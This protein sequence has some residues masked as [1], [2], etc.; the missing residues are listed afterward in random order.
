MAERNSVSKATLITIVSKTKTKRIGD[1]PLKNVQ[2]EV[3]TDNEYEET[4]STEGDEVDDEQE[5]STDG[6]EM[7]DEDSTEGDEVDDEQEDS[8][9]GEGESDDDTSV[10]DQEVDGV[11]WEEWVEESSDDEESDDEDSY[12][13][14]SYD[15]DMDEADQDDHAWEVLRAHEKAYKEQIRLL[16][17]PEHNIRAAAIENADKGLICFLNEICLNLL[18]GYF[19]SSKYE[20]K[21]LQNYKE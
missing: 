1:V 9:D 19:C 3:K 21:L 10:D 13:E 7:D 8:T 17:E 18:R 6:K 5:D 12:D 20:K 16:R 11:L 14:D 15:E 2:F 4:A